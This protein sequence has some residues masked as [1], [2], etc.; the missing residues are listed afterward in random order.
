[1]EDPNHREDKMAGRLVPFDQQFFHPMGWSSA[2][3][4]P[5]R[6]TSEWPARMGDQHFGMGLLEEDLFRPIPYRG[7]YVR[8]RRHPTPESRQESSI[9]TRLSEVS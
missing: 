6:L 1:M 5:G 9:A 2:W 7:W 3:D 4:E 8:S